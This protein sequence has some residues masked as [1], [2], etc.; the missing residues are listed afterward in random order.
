MA[1]LHGLIRYKRH[2]LDEKRQKLAALNA[3]LENL[4]A[5]KKNLLDKLQH[6]KN[7]AAVDVDIARN[8]GAYM[9]R[10]LTECGALDVSIEHKLQEIQAATH[11]VQ[12]SYLEV[13]KLEVTQEARDTAEEDRLDK[14]ESNT[15]DEVAL[16][17]FRRKQTT[18]T[19]T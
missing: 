6:E 17:G 3:E 8:F 2:D 18:D 11:M 15:L 9:N 12:E 13:K 4:R 7:L 16:D 5:S 1:K 14:I 10:M 19:L